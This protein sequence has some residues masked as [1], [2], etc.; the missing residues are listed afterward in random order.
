MDYVDGMTNMSSQK[1]LLSGVIIIKKNEA[2]QKRMIAYADQVNAQYRKQTMGEHRKDSYITFQ[3]VI[4][5]FSD[6]DAKVKQSPTPQAYVDNLIYCLM[7]GIFYS[8]RRL[9][10]ADVMIK[11]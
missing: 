5:R 3:E 9:E 8:P 10:W 1:T 11:N 2:F 7:S 6:I 4:G